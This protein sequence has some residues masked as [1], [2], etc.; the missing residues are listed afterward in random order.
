VFIVG[1]FDKILSPGYRACELYARNPVEGWMCVGDECLKF[2]RQ[3]YWKAIPK[4]AS[5]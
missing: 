1:I 4:E 5:T 2:M 3:D